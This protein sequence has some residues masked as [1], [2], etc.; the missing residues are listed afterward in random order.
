MRNL[1]VFFGIKVIIIIGNCSKI[2]VNSSTEWFIYINVYH[3][4]SRRVNCI[5]FGCWH[6]QLHLGFLILSFLIQN[7]HLVSRNLQILVK[8]KLVDYSWRYLFLKISKI[9][10][11]SK[12]SWF[13]VRE[14]GSWPLKENDTI[15]WVKGKV[16]QLEN[17]CF[18]RIK[19]ENNVKI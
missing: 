11:D 5:K 12:I 4:K 9:W 15:G 14:Y 3:G 17:Q 10:F 6:L 18:E 19:F 16:N 13:Y 2:I 8:L 7:S 1:I